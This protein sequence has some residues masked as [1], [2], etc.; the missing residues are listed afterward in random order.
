[1]KQ[2]LLFILTLKTLNVTAQFNEI[3]PFDLQ[4]NDFYG[5]FIVMNGEDLVVNSYLNDALFE[6]AGA[7]YHYVYDLSEWQ[8]AQRILPDLVEDENSE[9]FGRSI[10]LSDDWMVTTVEDENKY[11]SIIFYDRENGLWKRHS[12]F[13][14]E[15]PDVGFGWQI[16]IENNTAVIGS[17]ADYNDEGLDTGVAYVYE[18]DEATETW[19]E[20]QQL[21]PLELDVEDFFGSDIY[22]QGDLLA[23]SARKEGSNGVNSGAVF[24]FEKDQIGWSQTAKLIP[25][26]GGVEDYFG[27]R[28]DGDGDRLIVSGYGAEN[29]TGSV[30]IFKN[31][32][33]G[34]EQEAR[35]NS[36]EL[37]E[38]DWFGSGIAIEG[39]V[40]IVG[41]RNHNE[42]AGAVFFFKYENGS[43]SQNRKFE[44]PTGIV[45]GRFGTS[46]DFENRQ[47]VVGAPFANNLQGS[48]FAIDFSEILSVDDSTLE[49]LKVYP[50]PSQEKLFLRFS[51]QQIQQVSI[52]SIDGI[53]IAT[54]DYSGLPL[55]ISSLIAGSYIVKV[56]NRQGLIEVGRFVKI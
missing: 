7:L 4:D 10:A 24:V 53:N 29:E 49:K 52:Y 41:A 40:A 42:Q 32:N 21:S 17:V 16:A 9:S 35:L 27:F 36:P 46:L 8:A 55:D 34:W 5:F 56:N 15:N 14:S 37:E 20:T 28:I 22:L 51:D 6:D 2:L 48:A 19:G 39:D 31:G 30:Y 43:W 50:N 13:R 26:D 23:I 38:G 54:Y 25:V 12:K 44:S 33:S 3:T 47:L 18:F 11:V 1:M 45:N